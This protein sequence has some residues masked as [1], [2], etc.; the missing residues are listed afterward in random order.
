MLSAHDHRFLPWGV[1]LNIDDPY[2][3]R[4]LF[5]KSHLISERG[6]RFRSGKV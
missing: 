6:H 4:G 1:A 2:P 3:L 5:G